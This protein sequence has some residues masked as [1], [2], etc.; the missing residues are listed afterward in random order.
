MLHAFR[1][2]AIVAILAA[3]ALPSSAQT[4]DSTK[5]GAVNLSYIARM[6]KAGKAGLARIEDLGR[7]KTAEVEIVAADLQR[8]QAEL[9]R[10]A[11]GIT[12]RARLDLQRAFDKAR[13][14][15]DRVQ[16]DAQKAMQDLQA[17]FELDFRAQLAPIIDEVSKEKGLQFVF[18][19]EEAAIVW[20]SPS[21]DISEDVVKRL[22]AKK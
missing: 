10:N 2:A 17:Q 6:S 18:G 7:Q 8:K 21:V 13:V 19:L 11:I 9:Q 16:Q 12:E 22:D 5:I 1:L 15:F 3:T 20:W 4:I 14:D